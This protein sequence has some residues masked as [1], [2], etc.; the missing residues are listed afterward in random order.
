M[1]ARNIFHAFLD[2]LINLTQE[3]VS[4]YD[5]ALVIGL[6]GF[7][8]P[9]V[10]YLDIIF[11]HIFDK[12]LDLVQNDDREDCD[13]FWGCIQLCNELSNPNIFSVDNWFVRNPQNV[14]YSGGDIT[15]QFYNV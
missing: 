10:E 14:G 8:E 7:T 11:G 5:R 1:E 15:H 3:C 6:H 2:Q 12:T 9:T 13:K 4:R